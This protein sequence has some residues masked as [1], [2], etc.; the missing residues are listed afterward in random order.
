MP[1]KKTPPTPKPNPKPNPKP[2]PAKIA[3]VKH[4][5]TGKVIRKAGVPKGQ[6]KQYKPATAL[7]IAMA[8]IIR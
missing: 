4:S 2:K 7:D 8:G 3:Y 6:A 5:G 1:T